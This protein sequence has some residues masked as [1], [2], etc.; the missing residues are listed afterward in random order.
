MILNSDIRFSSSFL[1][2]YFCEIENYNLAFV[3][4]SK[5][6]VTY[7]RSIAIY[8]K[9]GYIIREEDKVHEWTGADPTNGYLYPIDTYKQTR[10]KDVVKFAVWRD[11]V[12][13]L[14]SCYK[15]FCLERWMRNYFYYLDLYNEP[16][17]EHFMQFVRFELGKNNPISHDEHVRR[18][19]DFYSPSDVDFIIPIQKLDAFLQD[20]NVPLKD[21]AKN[22]TH[23]KFQLNNEKYINEIRE[24]YKEDYEIPK[25]SHFI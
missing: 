16:S 23:I 14:I 19:S 18:Q 2:N 13:R 8:A 25:L 20:Y 1:G 3:A 17:F 10:G 21:T 6:A 7:L 22:S 24:L 11:P 15:Y 4:I 9:T 5:N 12:E